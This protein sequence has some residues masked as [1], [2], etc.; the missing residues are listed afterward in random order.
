MSTFVDYAG[1]NTLVSSSFD[2]TNT[3]TSGRNEAYLAETGIAI[4]V[5]QELVG[6]NLH[7]NGPYGYSSWKQLRV[8]ENPV[9]RK[10]RTTNTMTFIV[11]PGPMRNVLSNGELRVRDRYSAL[12]NYTEPAITQ[13]AYPLV[14][15]VGRH[16][17]DEDGNVDFE[18]PQ[19][20]SIISSYGNQ[21]IAFANDRVSKL[22]K[23]DPDEEQTEYVAIKDMYLENGLN[24][25]DSPLTHW[26]FLQYRETIFPKAPQQFVSQARTRPQFV[27][28]F[29]HE[30][31]RRTKNINT[32][33][34]GFFGSSTSTTFALSQSTWPLDEDRQFEIRTFDGSGTGETS[35]LRS[36]LFGGSGTSFTSNPRSAAGNARQGEGR[37]MSTLSQYNRSRYFL[38]QNLADALSAA[39]NFNKDLAPSP[40]YMR[41]HGITGSQ[42]VSNPSGL[43][44][45]ETGSAVIRFQGGALWEAGDKRQTKNDDG[46]YTSA[47]KQP[48]YDTYEGYVEDVR[49][50]GKNYAIIPEFRMSSQV[51]DYLKSNGQI[52][53]DMF[54][55]SGGTSRA[56]NSSNSKFYEI[57][58]NTDFMKNFEVIADDHKDFTNGKVLSLRCKAIKKFL[59]YEG[60]YPCQRTVDLSQKFYDSYRDHVSVFNNN[61]VQ[62]PAEDVNFAFQMLMAPL[63]AP[64]ILFN[65]IKSG[66]A[67]DFPI[68]T[69]RLHTSDETVTSSGG[70][71]ISANF[72]KRIPFEALL[73]PKTY[74]ANYK[75]SSLEPSVYANL[76]AS[77]VWDGQGPDDYSMMANNFLAETINFFLP[78][79][80]L[81]T[82]VS[83]KQSDV[84]STLELDKVYGMRIK[85]KRSMSGSR[86][87]VYH[88]GSTVGYSA[89]QDIIL[90]TLQTRENFT[91]Y[92]RPSAFGPPSFG[93]TS[94]TSSQIHQVGDGRNTLVSL[95]GGQSYIV[96]DSR[97]G[98][99]FPY[100]P[101]YYHGESWCDI[102]V[103][104]SGQ[105][106]SIQDIQS[107][108]T[109]SYSRF[110]SS[111]LLSGVASAGGTVASVGP[112][113]IAN[114]NRNALQLSASLNIFGLGA[115]KEDSTSLV[116]DSGID[117]A[118]RWV[119]QSKFETPMLNFSHVS[120]SEHLTL[121]AYGTGSTSRG[122]WHQY[123]RIPDPNEGVSIAVGSIPSNYQ[124]IVGIG[125]TIRSPDEAPLLLDLSEILGF[126]NEA[127][128]V[129]QIASSKKISE[130]VVAIP[131]IKEAGERKFFKIDKKKVDVFKKGMTTI[132]ATAYRDLTNG[133]PS[134]Q[135]G[136]SVLDQMEKMKK[137]IFPPSFDFI[138][139][140]T[141]TV[142]PI[143]MYI[144][145]FSHTLTQ[146]DLQDIWQNLPPTIGTEM[147]VAEVAIT[148][149]LIK[150][151]LLGQGG[152]GGNDTIEMS[153][154]LKWMVFKVKQR[155]AS[156]YFKKTVLR[157][158][159][160]NTGVESGNVTQDEFGQT[161][162]IQYNWPYDFFSL[163]EM[164][165][166]D[167]EV[168]MG[169]V[170]FSSYTDTIPNWNAV[171]AD[172]EKVENMVGGLEDDVL[173]EVTV[174]EPVEPIDSDAVEVF[175]GKV[176]DY[177]KLVGTAGEALA[178]GSIAK[179]N[180][181]K[182]ILDS[183]LNE[184]TGPGSLVMDLDLSSNLGGVD[185]TSLDDFKATIGANQMTQAG[186]GGIPTE[187]LQGI[188]DT[189]FGLTQQIN[190]AHDTYGA[191]SPQVAA[192]QFSIESAIQPLVGLNVANQVMNFA[193]TN[194]NNFSLNNF[195]F[196]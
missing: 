21:Q 182:D 92:S 46:T 148:H 97:H 74:L 143:A 101:P 60:F 59:P 179:A 34:F 173:P 78:N 196:N 75:V 72:D 79:G 14:W 188:A 168:E 38:N 20:F 105:E 57:Y 130:A 61:L 186:G 5:E 81:T 86:P 135:I 154:K 96:Q 10:H 104:G 49:K 91:M 66:V 164:V 131:F 43:E 185:F 194:M 44:I 58:S 100:T 19:R 84:K 37:L 119:I 110:D 39:E 47:P 23:F 94:F 27:N 40:L 124:E 144:F 174:S 123:G 117:F 180:I 2:D 15:N 133:K 172:R 142:A 141:E 6:I 113:A 193:N 158:P 138:N 160:I 178:Q 45:G 149:P 114:I 30:R 126:S 171:Q 42:S 122:M 50:F 129:G 11:Q 4:P 189:V 70:S 29:R 65:S 155:A 140:D 62:L 67:V 192:L 153:D 187:E 26:E 106:I 165:R 48:F 125:G 73:E 161:S 53:L 35:E 17:K 195:V 108:C 41:R 169:N 24:K 167:A 68:M 191:N 77:I 89:P 103:T 157:N 3:I 99:N 139:F 176:E 156:N 13:K 76:S 55:I 184:L 1:L 87:S 71:L 82:M 95:G 132:N 177:N 170:D 137:Y 166:I 107:M 32:G 145:E 33:S 163:V 111:H 31:T 18:N 16:F 128:K 121:P 151:E 25:Q 51:T 7:R 69:S 159:E 109:A 175:M 147:E 93:Q 162:T 9:T 90:S 120:G 54:E 115:T 56:E 102:W 12:Y 52:E 80:E 150:K 190:S 28:F 152:E 116:V 85:M 88:N 8:S 127:S 183:A 98:Y 22:L 63:F 36:I 136:R 112:Q 83:K 118:D 134:S 64:G 181:D 146:T